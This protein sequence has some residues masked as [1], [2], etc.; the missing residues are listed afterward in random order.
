MRLTDDGLL[1]GKRV[2][3][4]WARDHEVWFAASF[5]C[6][7]LSVEGDSLNTILDFGP[8]ESL[9]MRVALSYFSEEGAVTNLRESDGLDFDEVRASAFEAWSE[10]L[11]SIEFKGITAEVDTIFTTA[12]YHTAL[13][14]QLFSDKGDSYTIF[15]LW[16]TYRAAHPLYLLTDPKAP[17]Y[18]NSL[19]E[20]SEQSDRLPVWHLAGKETDCMVGVHSVPVLADA[21]LKDIKGVDRNRVWK[22]LQKYVTTPAEGL[23]YVDSLGFL[24]ADKV[25]WS[26]SRAL[27]YC[28]DDAAMAAAAL[29]MGDMEKYEY[30]LARS[31]RYRE[32]FDAGTGFMRGKLSDGKWTEPFHPSYSYHEIAN[33]VEGNAWQYTWLVP[34]DMEG[35]AELFGGREG[36]ISNLDR[37]FTADSALNAEASVDITGMIGQYAHGNE[38]SHHIAYFYTMAGE[39]WKTAELI[40]HICREFYT[41]E[42]DGLI[43]NEDCGQMS[44]WYVFSALGFYP[45][46]PFDGNYY[47]GSPLAKSAVINLPNGRQFRIEAPN[48]SPENKY[49]KTVYLNGKP[50]EKNHITYDD[51]MAGGLLEYEM[52]NKQ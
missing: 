35:L 40:R 8:V 21:I 33:Y 7:V 39:P 22:E 31:R 36:F 41:T 44:S 25:N 16:D 50:Y 23:E 26:V 4:E 28:I 18:I 38:P 20:I 34:H 27:E 52:T 32:Y 13:A 11:S 9:A 24:P 19:L 30:H 12:L 10:S 42:P 6:P 47:F 51:I 29:K 5:S 46:C 43:G 45:V 49:I 2:S 37:L 1:V 14:P 17:A 3:D 48:N 15:S